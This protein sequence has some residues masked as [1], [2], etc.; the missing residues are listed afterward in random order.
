MSDDFDRASDIEM[1]D[2]ERSIAAQLARANSATRLTPTGECQNPR[3]CDEFETG[4]QK[5]F[6]GPKCAHQ[7][8]ILSR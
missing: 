1:R 4:S 7:H 5:L 6:C 3:C 8:K 2:R